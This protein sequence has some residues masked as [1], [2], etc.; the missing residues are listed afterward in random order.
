MRDEQDRDS[1]SVNN[2]VFTRTQEIKKHQPNIPLVGNR[3]NTD[4]LRNRTKV[5]TVNPVVVVVDVWHVVGAN[6][7]L[8]SDNVE[9]LSFTATIFWSLIDLA[10]SNS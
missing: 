3:D 1:D 4:V 8:T 5:R 6:R 7:R 10:G 9:P 2:N